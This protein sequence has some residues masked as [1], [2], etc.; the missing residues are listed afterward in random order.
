MSWYTCG[1]SVWKSFH[2]V[3]SWDQTQ[4]KVRSDLGAS[5]FTCCPISL[6]LN[7]S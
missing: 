7:E 1:K 2:H 3:G 5:A 4:L 6:A